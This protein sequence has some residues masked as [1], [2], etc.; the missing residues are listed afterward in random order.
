[1]SAKAIALAAGFALAGCAVGW[2]YFSI[3]RMSVEG[4]STRKSWGARFA[5]LALSRAALFAI[6]LVP[7]LW[8]GLAPVIGYMAGFVIARVLLVARA[9][10][11]IAEMGGA[12][13]QAPTG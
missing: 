8:L 9:R 11:E 1:M 5:V 7:A 2:A 6:V 3:L 12:K 4:V 13:T 10:R